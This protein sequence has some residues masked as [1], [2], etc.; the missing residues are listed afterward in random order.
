[1]K[2]HMSQGWRLALKHFYLVLLLFVYQFIWGFFLYRMIDAIV[3]PLLRRLPVGAPGDDAM[4]HFLAE[5]QFQLFKTELATPYLWLFGGLL[6]A[7][8]AADPSV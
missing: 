7:P 6:A 4:R 2:T 1:M 8:N 3:A 5:A